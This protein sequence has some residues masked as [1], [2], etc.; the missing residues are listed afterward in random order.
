MPLNIAQASSPM[1]P[2]VWTQYTATASGRVLKLV[3]CEH[4]STEYVYVLER[5]GEG[6]GTSLYWLNEDGAQANAASAAE[7]TLRQ[8]LE[9]DFD[10]VPCPVCGHYQRYMF[11]KLYGGS[12]LIQ[13]A[14]LAVVVL[15]CVGALGALYWTAT[16]VQH[17]GDRALERMVA[18]WSLLAVVGLIGVGLGALERARARRFDPNSEDQQARIEKGRLRAVTRA[19]F[20]AAEQRERETRDQ[21]I[22]YLRQKGQQERAKSAQD[23]PPPDSV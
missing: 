4:C 13:L 6:A 1:I 18:N 23:H 3:P 9:N 12:P 11:P 21:F 19:E 16:Y 22:E 5:E 17:P 10:P 15:G 8:Y 7:D 2:V 14:R 20:E